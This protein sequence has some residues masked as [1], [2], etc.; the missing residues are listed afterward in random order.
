[1]DSLTPHVGP[2]LTV[3]LAAAGAGVFACLSHCTFSDVALG[4]ARRRRPLLTDQDARSG[5]FPGPSL[6]LPA[7]P[8]GNGWLW[9]GCVLWELRE[10]P[11]TFRALQEVC[12]TNPGLLNTRLPELRELRLVGHEPG[13]YRLTDHRRALSAA[14][15]P[16]Q[17]WADDWAR[18]WVGGIVHYDGTLTSA[19][20]CSAVP[21]R[22]RHEALRSPPRSIDVGAD[23]GFELARLRGVRP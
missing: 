17:A 1:M 12:G 21:S 10:M 19:Q 3:G 23:K 11:L 13:G 14:I 18:D 8:T 5:T 15:H 22:C 16:L 7:E 4:I 2:G 6:Q 9:F 20:V